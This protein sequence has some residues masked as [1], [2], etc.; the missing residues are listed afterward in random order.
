MSSCCFFQCQV[1]PSSTKEKPKDKSKK[2]VPELVQDAP[3]RRTLASAHVPLR[4]LVKAGKKVQVLCDFGVFYTYPEV[5]ATQA[6]QKAGLHAY[7]G[8]R[9]KCITYILVCV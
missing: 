7:K 5:E 6:F 3:I 4:S 9:N 2:S 1:K 8:L